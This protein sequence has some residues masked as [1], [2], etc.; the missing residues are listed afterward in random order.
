MLTVS[1]CLIVRDE[2]E[3]LD[4]C[5]EALEPFVDELVVVDTGS[6]DRT[7]EIARAQ[8][9]LVAEVAWSEDF[10]AARN[11][12]LEL[13][14]SDWILSVDADEL[15]DPECAAGL[16]AL[17]D[18]E[19]AEAYLVWIDNLDGGRDANGRPSF[20]SVGTPRLF[21][22]R[23]EIRWERPVHETITPSLERLG[24]GPPEHSHLRLVHHGYLPEAM[25]ARGKHARNLAILERRWR[26]DPRDLYGGFKLAQTRLATGDEDGAR[27]VLRST[28]NAGRRL[29]D[30]PRARLPFLPLVVSELVRLERRAGALT[31]AAEV[32]SEGL[33]DYSTVGELLYEAAEVERACGRLTEAG[34]LY[35]EARTSGPWTDLYAGR[36]ETRGSLALTGVA[37]VA[38]LAGDLE[39]AAG[40]VAQAIELNPN[41]LEARTY[42]ARLCAV[43]GDEAEAWAGLGRLLEEAPGD[44][45][46]GLL[47]AEMAWARGEWDTARGF[48]QGALDSP[49]SAPAARAWLVIEALARGDLAGAA[50]LGAPLRGSDLPEA[51][52]LLALG[53]A[54]GAGVALD[55][56]MEAAALTGELQAWLGE[57]ERHPGAAGAAEVRSLVRGLE[58]AGAAALQS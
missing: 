41:D 2:E 30:G 14:T 33:A 18:D 16:R 34:A 52:A 13:A 15:F 47:A 26:E 49:R 48:W 6:S 55:P 44:P 17:L 32:A 25:A 1:A 57:L 38:V 8:G 39:L 35:A 22:N 56:R 53:A 45:H 58:D 37:K 31:V 50:A 43:R 23:P 10:A 9:A 36:P 21:R 28:W 7:V 40:C 11:A 5:L 4:A 42:E 54:T 12:C 27:D 24:A 19:S 51:G 46:V 20:H 29:A 3:H